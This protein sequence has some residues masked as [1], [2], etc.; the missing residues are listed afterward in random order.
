MAK[1]ELDFGE[2][3]VPPSNASGKSDPLPSEEVNLPYSEIKITYTRSDP[4]HSDMELFLTSGESTDP[5]PMAS[6]L[7][8]AVQAAPRN[9][10]DDAEV[11]PFVWFDL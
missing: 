11:S 8:P 1:Y 3:Y 7:L 9:G 4:A 10:S 2:L 5:D 6:L